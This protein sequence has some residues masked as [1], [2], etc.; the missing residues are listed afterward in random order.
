M[1]QIIKLIIIALILISCKENN[2]NSKLSKSKSEANIINDTL[3]NGSYIQLTI[4]CEGK[5]FFPT[6]CINKEK[7]LEYKFN[8]IDNKT[9]IEFKYDNNNYV[10]TIN[11]K[12]LDLGVDS[13]LFEN[14][15]KMILI[16]DSFLEYGHIF[17]IYKL[18][19][20]KIEY[21]S[22]QYFDL[23][24]DSNEK[25]IKYIFDINENNN[26][27]IIK[28]GSKYKDIIVNTSKS[29]LLEKNNNNK[30][31]VFSNSK[32]EGLW[33]IDCSKQNSGIE[34]YGSDDNLGAIIDVAP[35]AIFISAK[36]TKSDSENIYFL[37]FDEQDMESPLAKEN[38]LDSNISK[39]KNI[40]KIELK[41]NKIYFWWFGFYNNKSKEWIMKKS[42][43]NTKGIDE[44][45]IVL[46]KCTY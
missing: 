14:N 23:N 36:L 32:F 25:E 46:N 33:K 2:A 18:T 44:E 35:P 13:F 42:Q 43:F 5:Q 37:R 4:N 40:A 20:N 28:L 9:L 27:L 10:H 7:N 39:D 12:I 21:L 1:K 16:F 11:E 38:K 31:K 41:N 17:N 6:K 30:L 34:I 15:E 24:I 29:I 8:A 19:P 22:S 26:E 3:T 45:Y